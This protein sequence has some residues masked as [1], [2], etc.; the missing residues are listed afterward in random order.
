MGSCILGS[1]FEGRVDT[2]ECFIVF[3]E[4][5][6]GAAKVEIS[7]CIF[8]VYFN[9]SAVAFHRL[10]VFFGLIVMVSLVFILLCCFICGIS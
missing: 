8:G 10:F 5:I 4:L 7:Q 1:D 6:E 9:G 3:F 2:C